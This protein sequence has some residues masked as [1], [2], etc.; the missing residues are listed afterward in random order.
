[1]KGVSSDEADRLLVTAAQVVRA[2]TFDAISE[3]QPSA[4]LVQTISEAAVHESRSLAPPGGG[5]E[6]GGG[7][8]LKRVEPAGTA[9]ELKNVTIDRVR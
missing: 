2:G 1:L 4:A 6:A 8:R 5:V 9:I 3:R 7:R